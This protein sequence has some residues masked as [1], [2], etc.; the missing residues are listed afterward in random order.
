M[1]KR[2]RKTERPLRTCRHS[3]PVE[4]VMVK[5]Y[6]HGRRRPRNLTRLLY[7]LPIGQRRVAMALIDGCPTYQEVAE[8]LDLHIGTVHRHLARI[9]QNRPDLYQA[10]MAERARQKEIRHQKAEARARA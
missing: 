4:Q 8:R 1:S 3:E 2:G 10:L 9:R 6:S 5:K 7:S